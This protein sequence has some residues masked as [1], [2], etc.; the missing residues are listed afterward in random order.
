MPIVRAQVVIPAVSNVSEDTC[1]NTFH[2]FCD[3][4][5]EGVINSV[6]TAIVA[7]YEDLDAWKGNGAN[8]A[9]SRIKWYDLSDPEP[10]VPF[11][12]ELA[13]IS[14][15][16]ASTNAARELC[17]CVSFA[18]DYESGTSAARRRGRIYFGPLTST[19]V[20]SDGRIASTLVTAAVTAGS[21]LLTT[22]GLASEWS[23]GVYSPTANALY[24]VTN[25]WVD[26][27]IDIQR[28][29]GTRATVRTTF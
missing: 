3:D 14:S 13:G 23:W 7:F 11:E 22:S 12:N 20:G 16:S 26:N 25:G 2:F 4:T 9:A 1:V 5:S 19:A 29:R 15:T 27:E 6:Q 10:R 28:R 8:W 24:T 17:V 21:G 18:G